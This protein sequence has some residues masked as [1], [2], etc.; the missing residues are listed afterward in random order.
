[1]ED[2]DDQR[3]G[4]GAVAAKPGA[5]WQRVHFEGRPQKGGFYVAVINS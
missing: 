1:M 5:R 2:H 4:L 3:I